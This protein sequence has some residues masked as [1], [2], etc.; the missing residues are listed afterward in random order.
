MPA[1]VPGREYRAEVGVMLP[2]GEFRSLARSNSVVT[3]RGARSAPKAKRSVRYDRARPAG[4]AAALTSSDEETPAADRP[5][6]PPLDVGA[7]PEQEEGPRP[8]PRRGNGGKGVPRGGASD[9]H[10]R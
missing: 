10:R 3:P 7:G 5:W 4:S 2:S 9:Q 6:S 8:V 1:R